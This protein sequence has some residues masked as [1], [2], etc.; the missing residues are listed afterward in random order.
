V[1][2]S[3][4]LTSAGERPTSLSI[5]LQG[6]AILPAPVWW[7][8][9]IRCVGGILKR[10]AARNA[11]GGVVT[12][13]LDGDLSISARSAVLG[14]PIVPGS[15]RYYQTYYRDP[16]PSFCPTPPG[17]TFNASSGQIIQWFP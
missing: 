7:G 11:V 2:D 13:P 6:T 9:G 8:D 1:E 4:V 5:F 14:N 17:S 10:I 12:Y 15:S 16:V 3:V